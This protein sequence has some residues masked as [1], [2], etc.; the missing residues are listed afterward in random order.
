MITHADACSVYSV[1]EAKYTAKWGREWLQQLVSTA[2]KAGS[3]PTESETINAYLE[4]VSISV[5]V[6]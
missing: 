2:G 6:F 1:R 4:R 5:V 3:F